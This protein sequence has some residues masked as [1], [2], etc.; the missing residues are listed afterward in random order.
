MAATGTYVGAIMPTGVALVRAD[1]ASYCVQAGAGASCSTSPARA[2]A[3]R[4]A[5]ARAARGSPRAASER[6]V[7]RTPGTK[8]QS[9]V[10]DIAAETG[11]DEGRLRADSRGDRRR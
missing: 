7:S 11:D 9:A 4:P 5:P 3:R 2:G 10:T 1:A 8:R 6:S